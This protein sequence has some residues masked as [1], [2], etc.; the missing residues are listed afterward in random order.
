MPFQRRIS[1]VNEVTSKLFLAVK[2]EK[3][4]GFCFRCGMPIHVEEEECMESEDDKF[5]PWPRTCSNSWGRE[6]RAWCDFI[7]LWLP[8]VRPYAFLSVTPRYVVK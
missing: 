2:Y 5:G 1:I 3:V 4:I 7:M 8:I 6:D